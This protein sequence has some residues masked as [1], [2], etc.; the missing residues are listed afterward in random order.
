M[1][2]QMGWIVLVGVS[3]EVVLKMSAGASVGLEDPHP[4]R[5][6]QGL[7]VVDVRPQLHNTKIS[8]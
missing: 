6:S 5:H 7:L 1:Q 4:R 3:L 8:P 2:G